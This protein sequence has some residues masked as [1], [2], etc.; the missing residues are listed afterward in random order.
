M[1]MPDNDTPDATSEAD[2]PA[3]TGWRGSLAYSA[4]KK[5]KHDSA[6]RLTSQGYVRDPKTR[7]WSR[8]S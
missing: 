7:A 8:P 6:R 5:R 1:T 2:A 4:A 3:E